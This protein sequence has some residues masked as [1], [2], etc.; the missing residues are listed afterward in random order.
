MCDPAASLP[1]SDTSPSFP[2]VHLLVLE[3]RTLKAAGR[4]ALSG[5]IRILLSGRSTAFRF[6][7]VQDLGCDDLQETILL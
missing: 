1:L 4:S 6:H 7:S 3:G 2:G 5:W